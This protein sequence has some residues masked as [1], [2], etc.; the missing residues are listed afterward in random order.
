VDGGTQ[1]LVER[2]D[3][4]TDVPFAPHRDP[5]EEPGKP[6]VGKLFTRARVVGE[7]RVRA[8]ERLIRSEARRLVDVN[9]RGILENAQIL[10]RIAL[11]PWGFYRFANS[12][13]DRSNLS[14]VEGPSPFAARLPCAELDH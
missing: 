4:E 1:R 8:G 14:W 12:I 10:Q 11:Q 3:Q 13:E 7:E 5:Q 9:E 2:F 6:D